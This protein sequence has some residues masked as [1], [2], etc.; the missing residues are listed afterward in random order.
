MRLLAPHLR[1]ASHYSIGKVRLPV[2][3]FW[4]SKQ[5]SDDPFRQD[6]P[7]YRRAAPLHGIALQCFKL[8]DF[9]STS[10]YSLAFR[11]NLASTTEEW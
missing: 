1:G 5:G 2:I 11:N 7:A 4:Q 6:S 3:Y 10:L 9:R 8:S